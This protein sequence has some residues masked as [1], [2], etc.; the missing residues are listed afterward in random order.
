M[1][2]PSLSLCVCV[3][4]CVRC[5]LLGQEGAA[6]AYTMYPHNVTMENLP[7]QIKQFNYIQGSLPKKTQPKTKIPNPTPENVLTALFLPYDN[8]NL[9]LK[10]G[11]KGHTARQGCSW[12]AEAELGFPGPC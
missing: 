4:V 3:G 12:K 8:K 10:Q 1:L 6:V 7:Q 9:C 5:E 2:T 11:G